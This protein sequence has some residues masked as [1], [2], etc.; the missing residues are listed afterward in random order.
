MA[1]AS[2]ADAYGAATTGLET[3][4]VAWPVASMGSASTNPLPSPRYTKYG[5]N[6]IFDRVFEQRKSPDHYPST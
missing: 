5:A 4:T 3:E 2:V 6:D 1:A